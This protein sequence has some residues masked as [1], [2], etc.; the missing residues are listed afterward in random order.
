[1]DHA[2]GLAGGGDGAIVLPDRLDLAA[3][4]RL[5]LAC[6]DAPGDIAID[7]GAVTVATTP[8]FQVL[9]A[10]RDRQAARGLGFRIEPVSEGF[11][12]CARTLGVPISRLRCP[13]SPS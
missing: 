8:A 12:S 4:G 3:A 9:I 10:A 1:M 6:L 2:G 11:A 7:A 5:R 13:G